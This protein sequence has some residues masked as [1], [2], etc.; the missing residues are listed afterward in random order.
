MYFD[1]SEIASGLDKLIIHALQPFSA[2]FQHLEEKFV[3]YKM[4]FAYSSIE[5]SDWVMGGKFSHILM[6]IIT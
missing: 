6:A 3:M 2:G 4:F 5:Q 1:K